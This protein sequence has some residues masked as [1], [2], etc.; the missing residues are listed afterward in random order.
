[1][2][3]STSVVVAALVANAAITVLKFGGYLLTGSPAMLSETYHSISD[4]GNQ[5]FLLI[6]IFYG[7]KERPANTR[8]VTGRRSSSTRFS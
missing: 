2:A 1:M 6:G 8:S 4:T 7:R 5:V 3:S